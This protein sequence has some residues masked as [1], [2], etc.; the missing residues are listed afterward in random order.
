MKGRTSEGGRLATTN[1]PENQ[2]DTRF[3]RDLSCESGPSLSF[4]DSLVS[5]E[6]QEAKPTAYYRDVIIQRQ[7]LQQ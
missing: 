1:I 4:S 5:A 2:D 7:Q 3:Y 6:P